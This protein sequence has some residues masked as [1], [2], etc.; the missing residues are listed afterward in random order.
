MDSLYEKGRV[1]IAYISDKEIIIVSNE[2]QL[3]EYSDRDFEWDYERVEFTDSLCIQ[4]R[5]MVCNKN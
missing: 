1:M 2:K 3:E 5:M 4:P